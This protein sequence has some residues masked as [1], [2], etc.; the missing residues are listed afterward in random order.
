[1]RRRLLVAIL[2]TV[3][4]ALLLAGS[5]AYL[6]LRTQARSTTERNLRSEAVGISG[7]VSLSGRGANTV[8]LQRV[9]AGLR[10]DGISVVQIGPNG[11]VFGTPPDGVTV[12]DLDASALRNG[13]V[14]SGGSRSLVW[15]AAPDVR[16]GV[17][18]VAILTRD[19]ETPRAPIAWFAVAGGITMLLGVGVAVWLSGSLTEPLRRADA[20]TGRI[21]AGDLSVRLPEPSTNADDEVADLTRSINS[22]AE[23]LQRSRGLERQ[24]LLSVSHDLR[25]PL[26][27]IQ[28]YA[29]AIADGTAPDA[30]A[31]AGVIGS[32]SQRLARLVRDLLDLAKLDAHRFSFT[33]ST[34]AVDEVATDT[35]EGFRP[36]AEAAGL[37]LEVLDDPHRTTA[38]VDPDRLAQAVANLVENGIKYARSA[39]WVRTDQ[40]PGGVAVQVTDDGPGIAPADLPHVFER[41]YV[42]QHRPARK[43]SGSGLGLAIVRELVTSMGGQVH[44]ESPALPDGSGARLVIVVPAAPTAA[45]VPPPPPPAPAAAPS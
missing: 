15:A 11:R 3:A 7:L 42:A 8:R 10:L 22:M 6:L 29:E 2:G 23:A 41:L 27:S 19:V 43:E 31:A 12:A 1:M 13:Q 33:F 32:E 9:V 45:P 37:R 17:T 4:A 35:A 5:G 30:R 39:L 26:T 36:E 21:A 20:V 25:T 14:I 38:V 34:V 24:F 18:V 40:V 44:A 28:G 16:A